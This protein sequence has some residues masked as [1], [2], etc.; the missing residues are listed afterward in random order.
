MSKKLGNLIKEART[1]KGLTQ[2][3]L[4]AK[5]EGLSAS[6]LGSAERGESEPSEAQV[7]ALAKALGATQTSFVEAMSK[8]GKTSAKTS[9]AKSSSAKTSSSKTSSAKKTG[10]STKKSSD[11]SMKLTKAE[12]E[13]VTNYRKADASTKN[14][15][16]SLLKGETPKTDDLVGTILGGA[17][18]LLSSK[19]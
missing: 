17:I 9:S 16:Q 1:K 5:V 19:L 18:N 8:K 15:I 13:L 12:K 3:E 6:A 2:A 7:R 10:T 14:A 11:T 4:A